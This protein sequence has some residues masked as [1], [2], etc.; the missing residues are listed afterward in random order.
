MKPADILYQMQ[1]IRTTWRN[2]DFQIDRPTNRRYCELLNQ[3]RE[4][5]NQLVKEGR[6]ATGSQTPDLKARE[7]K[8]EEAKRQEQ[9]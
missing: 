8:R 3:R 2:N 1:E 9:N 4:R 7:A 6:V 5:V